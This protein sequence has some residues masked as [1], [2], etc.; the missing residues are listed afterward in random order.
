MP[1]RARSLLVHGIQAID[2]AHQKLI[3]D[4]RLKAL[5]RQ[6]EARRRAD[7]IRSL[8]S[9]VR[10]H[11]NGD[12]SDETAKW[13]QWAETHADAIDPVGTGVALP[14]DPLP[15][16]Q[17]LEPYLGSRNTF[18]YPWPPANRRSG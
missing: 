3:H 15:S 17:N 7:E 8:C 9:S 10:E 18:D 14:P 6:L 5:E 16:R 2:Q 1:G 4:H 12:V 11:A 13:L